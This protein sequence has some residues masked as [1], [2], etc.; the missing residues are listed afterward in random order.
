MNLQSSNAPA[1]AATAA[2]RSARIGSPLSLVLYYRRNMRRVA[3][4]LLILTLAFFGIALPVVIINAQREAPRKILA[5][6]DYAAMVWPNGQEGY[7]ALDVGLL[8]R[9]PGVA[10]I[11]PVALEDTYW[12]T[13]VGEAHGGTY[14]FGLDQADMAPV[15][16]AMDARLIGG[17]LPSP[18][19]P[20]VAMHQAVARARG[21]SIGDKIDPTDSSESFDE[22]F[23]V[24]GLLDGP[25]PLTLLSREY[26]LSTSEIHDNGN[27]DRAWLIINAE[28]PSR[29]DGDTALDR[30]L[31]GLSKERFLYRGYKYQLDLINEVNTSIDAVLIVLNT[32]IVSVLTL[33]VALLNYIYF[34]RRLPEFGVLMALGQTRGSLIRRALVET[35]TMIGLTWGLGLLVTEG[36]CQLLNTALLESKGT[37]LTA[38]EPRVLLF[39]LPLVVLGVLSCGLTIYR[40]LSRLDPVSIVELRD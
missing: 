28:R 40:Q 14:G 30:S 10:A 21:L 4:M 20:E 34:T 39:S 15:M 32:V 35:L 8:R 18:Y 37:V 29:S 23:K 1:A 17:R 36:F 25:A 27:W 16:R 2:A 11:Y 6:F 3:P 38:F 22:P 26:L 9:M 5:L 7:N 33:A 12:P 19:A 13:I 24:V 31:G